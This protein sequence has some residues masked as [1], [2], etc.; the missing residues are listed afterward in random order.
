MERAMWVATTIA[1]APPMAI[2][3][4]LRAAWMA[5]ESSRRNALAEISMIVS[6]GTTF[7]NISAGQDSFHG[8]RE[9]PRVR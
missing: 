9:K 6:L 2:Q 3:G 8:K 7:D 1:S 4:T 5:L